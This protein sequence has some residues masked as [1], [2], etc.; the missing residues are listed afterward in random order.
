ML[1]FDARLTLRLTTK[2]DR[3]MSDAWIRTTI[4][5]MNQAA[6]DKRNAEKYALLK[7]QQID[8]REDDLFTELQGTIKGAVEKINQGVA[9]KCLTLGTASYNE[10]EINTSM[11]DVYL[12]LRYESD[13]HA[14]QYSLQKGKGKGD[15]E[16]S[17]ELDVT[18]RE[19]HYVLD[20]KAFTAPRLAEEFLDRLINALLEK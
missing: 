17:A 7:S 15:E 3:N 5:R 9:G 19:V 2:G 20:G 12:S 8:A 1:T 18:D 16:G 10:I 11:P 6:E 4:T 14:L 13:K